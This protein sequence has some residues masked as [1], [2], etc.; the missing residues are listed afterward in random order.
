MTDAAEAMPAAR[1]VAPAAAVSAAAAV[2]PASESVEALDDRFPDDRAVRR[3]ALRDL[4]AMI[5]VEVFY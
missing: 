1:P 2:A 3:A 5:G 4:A